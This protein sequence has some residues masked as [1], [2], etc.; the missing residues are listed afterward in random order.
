MLT[1]EPQD[2]RL[3]VD[4]NRTENVIRPVA[5]GRK[6]WLSVGSSVVCLRIAD[7][8]ANEHHRPA[9]VAT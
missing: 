5:V 8:G 9:P 3:L 4:N 6:N 1:R 2:I 7:D